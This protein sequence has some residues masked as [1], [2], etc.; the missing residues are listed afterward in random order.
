VPWWIAGGWAIELWL[1]RAI[2]P[3]SDLE[4][5][6]FQSDLSS[7]LRAFEGWEI[8]VARNKQLTPLASDPARLERPFSLWLRRP[9]HEQWDLE[10]LAEDRDGDRWLFRRDHRI[11][12]PV[13]GLT[14]AASGYSVIRPEVQLLFKS[15]EPRPKDLEDYRATL[16]ALDA[17]SR[18][19]LAS[20][21]ALIDAE[22]PWLADL[23]R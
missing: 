22:H 15:R 18:S 11:S 13:S 5:G 7:V 20:A 4:I 19:W 8:A 1:G 17:A 10:I 23:R 6:C 9:G 14:V 21:L 2:R 12:R 3:H 16:P